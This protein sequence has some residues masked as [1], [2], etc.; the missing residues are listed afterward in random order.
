ML[1]IECP[2]C[3]ERHET[4]FHYGGEAHIVRPENP[5]ELTDQQWAEFLFMKSNTKGV[6]KERWNHSNG[7]R[8]WFNA[9]RHTVSHEILAVYKMGEQPPE[10]GDR[11]ADI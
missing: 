11:E 2:W 4:E 6:F 3:G 5:E 1:L 8:R 7:C 10:L 9:I